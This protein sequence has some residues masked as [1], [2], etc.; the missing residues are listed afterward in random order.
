MTIFSVLD[1]SPIREGDGPREAIKNSVDLAIE[2]E[3]LGFHRY[4]LA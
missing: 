4:W 1:L 3:K 2:A